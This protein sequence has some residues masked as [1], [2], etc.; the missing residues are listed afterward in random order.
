MMMT[1]LK[2]DM[3]ELVFKEGKSYFYTH[4]FTRGTAQR[5]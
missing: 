3:V 5:R 4:L 2:L 1:V